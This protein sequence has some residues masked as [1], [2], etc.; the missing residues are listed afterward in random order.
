MQDQSV[1]HII[2]YSKGGKSTLE[3]YQLLHIKCNNEKDNN[4]HRPIR[5]KTRWFKKYTIWLFHQVKRRLS[6]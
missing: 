4:I 6:L 5:K 3:N 1:D 2:P